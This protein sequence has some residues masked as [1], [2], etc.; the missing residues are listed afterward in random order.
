MWSGFLVPSESRLRVPLTMVRRLASRCPS[1][2]VEETT[3]AIDP[4][5]LAIVRFA[6][7]LRVPNWSPLAECRARKFV[8]FDQLVIPNVREPIAL[9]DG[10]SR[11]HSIAT[12][13]AATIE[14]TMRPPTKPIAA[15]MTVTT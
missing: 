13:A 1:V 15:R 7:H 11:H 5:D 12:I 8:I 2:L 9:V 3:E 14:W 10:R 6:P 4:D